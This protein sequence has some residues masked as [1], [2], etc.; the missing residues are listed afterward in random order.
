MIEEDDDL[1]RPSGA[2]R[3]I[4]LLLAIL[5]VGSIGVV[6]LF[7]A[8][9]G[10]DEELRIGDSPADARGFKFIGV[11]P[12]TGDPVRFD[13]CTPIRYVVNPTNAPPNALEDVHEAIAL[14]AE[15]TGIR[16]V[17][18]G[19][20]DE[21][22]TPRRKPYQPARYG[23]RWAPVLVGWLPNDPAVF[24]EHGA[25]VGGSTAVPN[26]DGTPVYVSGTITMNASHELQPGFDPGRTWGKVALHELGHVLGLDHVQNPAQVMNANLV[27]S[28]AT[29][30]TGDLAGLRALGRLSGC[31]S[32]PPPP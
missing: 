19:E 3:I 18:E 8:L 10:E 29:W 9:S 24:E 12:E 22:P 6:R 30:G 14:T 27:S 15:V 20:T 16:F 31:V 26:E 32:P 17:Y 13:P 28:A 7:D 1:S 4:A 25:G 21:V 5:L 23:E 11:D 2:T